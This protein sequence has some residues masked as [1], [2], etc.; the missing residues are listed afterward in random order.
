MEPTN[1]LSDQAKEDGLPATPSTDTSP[2]RDRPMSS[3]V[4][5]SRSVSQDGSSSTHMLAV[6]TALFVIAALYFAKDLVIPFALALLLTFLLSTP[7]T[8]LERAH[9]GRP[10]SVLVVLLTTMV[11]AGG[12]IWLGLQQLNGIA[13]SFPQYRAHIL[14]KLQALQNPAGTSLLTFAENIEQLTQELTTGRP[15]AAENED[16]PAGSLK[17][18]QKRSTPPV[19]VEIV[20]PNTG[21]LSSLGFVSTSLLHYLGL[22][23]A[24]VVMTLFMLLNRGHLRNRLLRLFGQGHLVLMTTALDE[25]ARKVSRYLLTQSCINAC[26]GTLLGIG[27]WAIGV[28]YAPFW[29][30]SAAFLRF[31][32][33]VGTFFAGMSPV[34]LS[35]A[36]FDG[37]SKPLLCL[38]VFVAIE[39]T[40]SGAIEPWLYATRT[41]VSSLAILISAAFWTLLWGPIGLL[42]ATPLTVCLAVLGRHLPPLGFL[43]VLL[44][45]EPVLTPDV[46]YYQRLLAMDEEEA[47]DLVEVYL[48][49]KTRVELYDHVLIPALGLAEQDRH[50]NRLEERRVQ[51]VYRST[52]ELLDEIAQRATPDV[53]VSA[54]LS[55]VCVPVRDEADE[56]V[57]MML[58]Q[59]LREAGWN[60]TH[61]PL[62]RASDLR[63]AFTQKPPDVVIL[64]ALPP[65]ALL[66]ARAVCRQLRRFHP[67]IKVVLGIWNIGGSIDKIKE[68]LGPECTD[69]I[70]ATI[71]EA[72]DQLQIHLL[73]PETSGL[74]LSN[75]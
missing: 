74:Y 71:R 58:A 38:G 61:W 65:S 47:A 62:D 37:W 8:W 54:S 55:V 48:K 19:R 32:P 10:F 24:V 30:V 11:L 72:I 60:A 66:P 68:R 15:A 41:G 45:D 9:F 56:L 49:E 12:L 35:L 39:A 46:G 64:S 43:H 16:S 63:E 25:A 52:R 33:Y 34:V 51:F 44:G 6:I 75:I 31:I 3:G 1:T 21:L 67:K 22:L 59:S 69:I 17:Q 7:V 73:P 18:R 4:A 50:R 26:F 27:V 20:K 42:L 2:E 14:R 29:G 28:P 53:A 70:V 40:T 57:A 5:T 13:E 36:A 23:A